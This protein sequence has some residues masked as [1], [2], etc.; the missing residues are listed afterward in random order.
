MRGASAS[1]EPTRPRPALAK[2]S[3]IWNR[4]RSAATEKEPRSNGREPPVVCSLDLSLSH[5]DI[6]AAVPGCALMVR[7]CVLVAWLRFLLT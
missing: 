1:L 2:P 3:S 6:E 7:V 4:L 5:E